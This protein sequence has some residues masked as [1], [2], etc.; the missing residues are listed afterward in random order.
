MT[1]IKSKMMSKIKTGPAHTLTLAPNLIRNLNH[2]LNLAHSDLRPA[3][4]EV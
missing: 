2:H 1:R 3:G 4:R